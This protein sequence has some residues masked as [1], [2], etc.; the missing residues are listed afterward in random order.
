MLCVRW[1]LIM[2]WMWKDFPRKM[3]KLS[4]WRECVCSLWWPP[5]SNFFHFETRSWKSLCIVNC[6]VLQESEC[7]LHRLLSA[8]WNVL[9][10]K[11]VYK[12]CH[13]I[14]YLLSWLIFFLMHI[15]VWRNWSVYN[16]E[17]SAVRITFLSYW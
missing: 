3:L 2:C 8:N 1:V 10:H 16:L 13:K 6:K 14:I 5:N 12:V 7:D 4:L 9:S 17:S 11:H 15:R